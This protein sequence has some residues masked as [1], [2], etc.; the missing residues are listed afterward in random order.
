MKKN[1]NIL[2]LSILAVSF[3]ACNGGSGGGN[4]SPPTPVE[5]SE[6]VGTAKVADFPRTFSAT[7]QVLDN[8]TAAS[9]SVSSYSKTN[10]KSLLGC[11][12]TPD[13]KNFTFILKNEGEYPDDLKIQVKNAYFRENKTNY[14]DLSEVSLDG[15][16]RN[17]WFEF[18]S[19]EQM[20]Q[21][22]H[23]EGK[24]ERVKNYL[25]GYFQCLYAQPHKKDKTIDFVLEFSC[26]VIQR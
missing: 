16:T 4:D 2:C 15:Y 21:L 5:Q 1:L 18:N 19:K 7:F 9:L 17:K 26:D 23:C 8:K 3:A 13:G 24:M 10:D 14:K 6:Q 25:S 11:M 12:E 22:H 20:Y